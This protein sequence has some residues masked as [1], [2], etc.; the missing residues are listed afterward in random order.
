[1][2]IRL[3]ETDVVVVGLGAAGGI[4]VLPLVQAG[5]NVI[6]LEAGT[7][8]TKR[9]FAPDE[10]RNNF[11][12]WPQAVQ[13]ANQEIPTHRP[14]AY[15]PYSPRMTVHPMMNAV[16]GTTLHYW[17]QSWRLN[18]WDFKVVSETAR[19]YGS[20]RIPKGSTVEDWPLGLEEL[21]PYYDKVEFEIGVSGKAGN[22][23]GTV[24]L[25]GNKFEG[26]R[27]R[28]YP[29][30]PLRGTGFTE[31]MA[32]AARDLGWHPFP[33]PAA[34]NSQPYQNRS[35]CNYHGFCNRGGCHVDAKNSTAITTIP[36]A[37]ETGGLS[38]V[39][40]ARVTA[41]E[42]NHQGRVS[43]V[44]YLIDGTEYFQP[45][46]VVLLASYVY[47]NVRLLLLS[48]SK[49][50]PNGLSNRHGQVGKHYFSHNQ[51]AS[52]TALF[53]M[54][55]NN[56]YGLPGQGVAVDNWADDNFDH[57]ALDFI[58]GGNLWV[59]SDRRPIGAASMNTFG[60]VPAWGSA[61]KAFIK[62]NADR[63]NT[64]YLQKTTLPYEDNYLDLD[65]TVKDP[66]GY[67]V[68]RITAD[69]K[70]NEHKLSAFIQDKMEHW[71]KSAGAI[72]TVRNPIGT[73]GPATHAYGGTRMGDNPET[74]VV[75]RW[76]FSH[77][78]PNLGILGGSVMGTSG[79]RNP[80]LTLQALAWRTAEHLAQN[81][82]SIATPN[83]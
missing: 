51:G 2:A 1:M 18:P 76:G 3:K 38:V 44:S 61:W 12:G 41:L 82:N 31:K 20:G 74:N 17:A 19:R 45:A 16:G 68:C 25:N 71:Y 21:E 8:L 48:N 50:Y 43:G 6:G 83:S 80:T 42:V 33:G 40:R 35:A 26:P 10:L 70:D 79:A 59:Y 69:Y 49:P 7:W 29:M 66:L 64:A 24:D 65:P 58:G 28:E 72:A 37:M 30:P 78:A 67:P 39:T 34:I 53:S 54:N 5:L 47:E 11:R 77:E 46:S 57:A 56:W 32:N 52:V 62:E 73:M 22:I 15:A 63:W 27:K 55:L 75:D 60:K 23:G 9:D 36:K 14:N 4:A 13:K 81:W